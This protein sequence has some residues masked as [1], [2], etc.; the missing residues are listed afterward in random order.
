MTHGYTTQDVDSSLL[1][2]ERHAALLGAVIP[3]SCKSGSR[4]TQE[5]EMMDVAGRL[6][7][8]LYEAL[9]DDHTYLESVFGAD[10]GT[11]IGRLL[12]VLSSISTTEPRLSGLDGLG[13]AASAVM[14][15][16]AKRGTFRRSIT[17]PLFISTP[18]ERLLSAKEYEQ[19]DTRLSSYPVGLRDCFQHLDA[20]GDKLLKSSDIEGPILALGIQPSAQDVRDL[21]YAMS[22]GG[23]VSEDQFAAFM[24]GKAAKADLAEDLKEVW[25]WMNPDGREYMAPMDLQA[26]LSLLGAELS[27]SDIAEM[28]E[29]TLGDAEA[30]V[31]FPRFVSLLSG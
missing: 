19:F 11:R 25:R 18:R 31:D 8:L 17:D 3:A 20:D 15:T 21:A 24:K 2:L 13:D 30:L 9:G 4:V 10:G 29:R 27:S 14:A 7:D 12:Q 26:T 6:R 28:L 5:M 23:A 1:V 22:G 16:L